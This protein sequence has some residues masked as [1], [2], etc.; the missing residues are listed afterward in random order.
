MNVFLLYNKDSKLY[1][2]KFEN[3][4]L[5]VTFREYPFID[6]NVS[7]AGLFINDHPEIYYWKSE[8]ASTQFKLAE[9]VSGPNIYKT[10]LE[11]PKSDSL[12]ISLYSADIYY[13]DYPSLISLIQSK[14]N[15]YLLVLSGNKI[16][17]N[18]TLFNSPIKYIKKFTRGYF[19]G[20]SIKG[21]ISFTVKAM[22]D[23]YIYKLVF[24]EKEKAFTLRKMLDA[25]DVSDYFFGRLDQKNYFLVY[26]NKKEGCLSILSLKK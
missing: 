24:N 15:N 3:R 2:G 10:F 16:I 5:S 12:S 4:D 1:L 6:R 25:N 26:S 21:I 17:T 8:E 20:T 14:T 19:G 13:N 9:V 23:A 11:V 18:T 22:D 7:L